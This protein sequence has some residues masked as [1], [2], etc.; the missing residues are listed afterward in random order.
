MPDSQDPSERLIIQALDA[1]K[2]E[3]KEL[4]EVWRSLDAK[5]QG[6][7]A[8]SGIFLA[9]VFAFVNDL[10]ANAACVARCLLTATAALLAVSVIL[11]LAVLWVRS[12]SSA[13]LGESLSVLVRDLLSADDGLSSERLQDYYKDQAH[14]WKATNEEVDT[15]NRRKAGFLIAAQVSLALGILCGITITFMRIWT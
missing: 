10:Q 11:A 8:I 12:V 7:V 14:L 2:D 3:Y 15:A 6:T 13:P 5:A 9:G 1:H 4:A